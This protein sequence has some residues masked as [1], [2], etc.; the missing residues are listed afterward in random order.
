MQTCAAAA[1]V[2]CR[3]QVHFKATMQTLCNVYANRIGARNANSLEHF[4]TSGD[5]IGILG[6]ERPPNLW[7]PL[8]T[9]GS[10]SYF[11]DQVLGTLYFV[12]S[13]LIW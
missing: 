5:F 10:Q 9:T 8:F 13:H 2:I 7:C 12:V 3:R 1:L 4:A 11:H 6:P